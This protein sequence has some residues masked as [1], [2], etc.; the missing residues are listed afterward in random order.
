MAGPVAWDVDGI[1][2]GPL[3]SP[4]AKSGPEK[5]SSNADN[6]APQGA[7]VFHSIPDRSKQHGHS[8]EQRTHLAI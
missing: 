7:K 5:K 4:W 1:A 3:A 8:R 2:D 6:K